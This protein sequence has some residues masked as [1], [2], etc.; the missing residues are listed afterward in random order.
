MWEAVVIFQG[1]V[2][3]DGAIDIKLDYGLDSGRQYNF[4]AT[5]PSCRYCRF[6]YEMPSG[7]YF[8]FA[9]TVPSGRH[10]SHCVKYNLWNNSSSCKL[11]HWMLVHMVNT[12]I[13]MSIIRKV[14]S[15]FWRCW[16]GGR[17]VHLACKKWVVGC[18]HGY[19]SRAS[20]R[21]AYVPADVTATHCLLLQ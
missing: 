8:N 12:F 21:L 18:W 11:I 7:W 13:S 1:T 3:L 20:C 6:F 17:K 9:S 5:V 19:L 16:L 14:P 2:R 10:F 4:A 15:V